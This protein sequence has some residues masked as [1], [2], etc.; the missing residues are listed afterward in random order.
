MHDQAEHN[1]CRH[2][3]A[4]PAPR[5]H[6]NHQRQQDRAV[7][8]VRGVAG[9]AQQ[10]VVDDHHDQSA[11]RRASD[12]PGAAEDQRG[13]NQDQE[14]RVKVGREH[15]DLLGSVDRAREGRHH[16]T[17]R[18]CHQ[19][20]PVDRD[21]HRRGRQR[22]FTHG[23]PGAPG[24]RCLQQPQHGHRDHDQAYEQV[25]VA[26]VRGEPI[27]EG[28]DRIDPDDAVG[29]TQRAGSHVVGELNERLAEEQRNDCQVV[30][31]QSAGRQADEEPENRRADHHQRQRCQCGQMDACTPDLAGR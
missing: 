1:G 7:E 17:E 26:Q 27:P 22:V 30:A 2:D 25:V 18:E 14:G 28:A 3:Q 9:A 15:A 24:A 23:P 19:P 10:P 20:D 5:A 16:R 13:V 11:G 8:Q 21:R 31:E 12:T 6:L 4:E 29:T